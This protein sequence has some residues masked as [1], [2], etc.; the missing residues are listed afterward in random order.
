L[1]VA[2]RKAYADRVRW[3]GWT[4]E[5]TERRVDVPS[6]G[7]VHPWVQLT[8][9]NFPWVTFRHTFIF[10]PDGSEMTSDSTLRFRGQDEIIAS[11]TGAGFAIQNIRDAPDRPGRELVFVA[12]KQH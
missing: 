4:R 12:I 9:A 3:L 11:L 1:D 6:V 5:Q 2:R 10:E 7:A 8:N